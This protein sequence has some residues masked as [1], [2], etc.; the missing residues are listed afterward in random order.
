M[1]AEVVALIASCCLCSGAAEHC[2]YVRTLGTLR[3]NSLM[4]DGESVH[5][6]RRTQHSAQTSSAPARRE[7]WQCPQSLPV[8]WDRQVQFF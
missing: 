4:W 8:F 2:R 6:E 3:V 5:D 7:D 1:S